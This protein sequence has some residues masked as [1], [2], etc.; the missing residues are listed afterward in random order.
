MIVPLDWLAEYV[1]LP[2]TKDLT[3]RLTMI[4]HML[5]KIKRIGTD[6]VIDLELR[7][8]RS[9]MFGLIGVAR[10]VSAAFDRKLKLPPIFPLPGVDPKS[11]HL[12]VN[13]SAGKLVHR[14][15]AL[16]LKVR[17]GPSPGWLIKKLASW[18][19]PSINNVVDI[20]NFVMIETG[21]PLHSFDFHRISGGKLI[22][23]RGQEN[24]EFNTIQQGLTVRLSPEDLVISDN[25]QAQ[26]LTMI[27][28][29]FSRV[30]ENTSEILL[31]SAVYDQANSRHSSHRLKIYTHSSVR[32]EK[33]L[34]PGQVR[35]ALERAL[36]LLKDLADAEILSRVSEY[37]PHPEKPKNLVFD[38]SQISGLGGI[39][40]K[41]EKVTDI[42][43]R[44]EFKIGPHKA[45]KLNISIPTIRTDIVGSAD[46]VEEVL[47][48]HG[49]DKIP[50][51]PLSGETPALSTYPSYSI[52]EKVRDLFSSMG[53]NEI[54]SFPMLH[55]ESLPQ[56]SLHGYY[57]RHVELENS[58]DPQ[59]NVLR[60][61][62]LP[63]L[64][65]SAVK[66]LHARQPRVALF[67]IGKTFFNTG[68]IYRES[69]AA[70]LV[71]SG[72]DLPPAWN[73]DPKPMDYFYIKG[74]IEKLFFGLGLTV[75]FLPESGH[76][77]LRLAHCAVIMHA[78]TRIGVIGQVEPVLTD[79]FPVYYADL[80]LELIL[81]L[82]T[83]NPNP[84]RIISKFQPIIEDINFDN[85][86]NYSSLEN[87]I[88]SLSPLIQKIEAVDKYQHRLTLRLTFHS[89]QIQLS[90]A[91]IRPIRSK[92]EKLRNK[93][94]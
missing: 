23:R 27:G 42:L 15:T 87:K 47:R 34:D 56:Y 11:P 12:E 64:V 38:L 43:N 36:Y 84:Y 5:D 7:G 61:T 53:V 54:I 60:P 93:S 91:D 69:L 37:Y 4:G 52:Q 28:G 90:S 13:A 81:S 8:N 1:D 88:S 72:M 3:D 45:G 19:I 92:L 76:P 24:E 66:N 68:N 71:I 18:E 77:S 83:I 74:L 39:E 62:L 20:T 46:V 31:E 32:H 82:P 49:Y 30:T 79:N 16:R 33:L 10:E 22:L 40:I 9:D 55:R 51:V 57:P 6:T 85:V 63:N 67:E 78:R 2:E 59:I 58:I 35:F 86:V 94:D 80:D 25:E 89:D 65:E 73:T 14:Y 50:S 70:G 17:V 44:L 75:I 29:R 21:Q 41:L 48:I 26:A